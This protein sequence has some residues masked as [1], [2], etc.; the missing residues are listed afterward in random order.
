MTARLSLLYAIAGAC[1]LVGL[2]TAG[3]A[4]AAT[5]VVTNT[6]DSGAG[7]LRDAITAAN[8]TPA[9]D[10]I[11]FDIPGAGSHL[12]AVGSL[13][14]AVTQPLVINGQSQPGFAG[15]PLIQLAK[16]GFAARGLSLDAGSVTVKGLS[17]TGFDVGI[18][19]F[20]PNDTV[21]GCWIGLGPAG[22]PGPNKVGISIGGPSAAG[23]VVGGTSN[24]ARNVIS[25]NTK[26]GVELGAAGALVQGNYIGTDPTGR[27]AIGNEEGVFVV[28]PD[29]S[30]QI[31]GTA[32]GARNVI[33]GNHGAGV[34]LQTAGNLIEGNYVGLTASGKSRLGNEGDGISAS[35]PAGS[36]IGGTS[37]GARNVVSGNDGQGIGLST[38]SSNVVEG[39]FVGTDASGSY[40][41]RNKGDGIFVIGAGANLIGG[42]TAGARNVI[43]GQRTANGIEL[44]NSVGNVVE[45]NY[46]GVDAGGTAPLR[47][48]QG[49]TVKGGSGNII[50]G[51]AAGAGNVISGNRLQ[52]VFVLAGAAG[53]KVQG[54]LIGPV[55]TG[56]AFIGNGDA[57]VEILDASGNSVGGGSGAG[58]TI[59]RNGAEGV[60]VDG[61]GG[62]ATANSIRGNAIFDNAAGGIVLLNGG[63]DLQ[64]PPTITSVTTAAG[65]T[66][67]TVQ[68]PV[69]GGNRYAVEVF[70]SPTCDPLD[71]PQ[72]KQLVAVRVSLA[73]VTGVATLVI[74]VPELA[75]EEGVTVTLTPSNKADTSPF[76]ACAAAP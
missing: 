2:S 35:A 48:N 43:S 39:N 70:A 22:D 52:G 62:S 20:G 60:V 57:G 38:S 68:F 34:V 28:A 67:V 56:G 33:S 49:V 7:S 36:T 16:G 66:T 8:A 41:I 58:N 25:G 30:A 6:D 55:A 4:G 76:S 65:A 73:K 63:N 61:A 29:G 13:L 64:A 75:P 69:T 47:N 44:Q 5:F 71:P 27:A 17:I 18:G 50:G 11:K 23:D 46:I 1:A 51:T 54:N 26:Q 74:A 32:A 45:G 10:V 24:G 12:I 40:A 59:A 37:A 21:S 14:P 19:V 42:T 15:T 9:A 72:G 53:T 3:P 31:G